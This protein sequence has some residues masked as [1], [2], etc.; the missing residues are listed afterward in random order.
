M[1]NMKHIKS[2]GVHFI[3]YTKKSGQSCAIHWECQLPIWV[4]P[5]FET[6]NLG[7]RAGWLLFAIGHCN[8]P[9]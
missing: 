2:N 6:S 5:R 7:W 3:W 8:E 4:K 9:V 1:Y